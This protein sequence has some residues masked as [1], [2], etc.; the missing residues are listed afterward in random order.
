M[1]SKVYDVVVIGVADQ[2]Y[3]ELIKAVVVRAA[4]ADCDEQDLITYAASQLAE[5]KT[6]KIIEFRSEIPYSP[7]GKVLRK[8]L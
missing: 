1:D 3:G 6:P 5:Y 4:G 7:L 8:Y 2:H